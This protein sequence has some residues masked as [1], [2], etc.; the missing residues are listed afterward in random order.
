MQ[1]FLKPKLVSKHSLNKG[2][3]GLLFPSS[4]S[5]YF[6]S[7]EFWFFFLLDHALL[8]Y[9]MDTVAVVDE[10]ECQLKCIENNSCK[11]FNVGSDVNNAQRRICEL[12]N[13]TRQM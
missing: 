8:G 10:F 2:L 6:P 12:N 1:A 4:Q 13:E 9:V 3:A 11:S 5:F 7:I